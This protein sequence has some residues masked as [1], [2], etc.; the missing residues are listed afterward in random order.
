MDFNISLIKKIENILEMSGKFDKICT[1]VLNDTTDISKSKI[2]NIR[3]LTS[4]YMLVRAE[5]GGIIILSDMMKKDVSIGDK[6]L[7]DK[8]INKLYDLSTFTSIIEN[9]NNL[10]NN[11]DF[12]FK[13]IALMF[14]KLINKETSHLILFVKNID[15]SNIFV[16]IF[17]DIKTLK[18][19]YDYHVV[20]CEEEGKKVDCEKM[21]GF[22]LSI[23]VTKLPSIYLINGSNIVDLPLDS[24]KETKD[25]IKMLD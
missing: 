16:K 11:M 23:N 24:I 1:S 19:E 14:P 15:K 20:E 13:K 5:H 3:E 21:L 4:L 10:V 25:L 22:K 17:E 7:S 9:I 6:T 12:E 8:L 2:E 18:P